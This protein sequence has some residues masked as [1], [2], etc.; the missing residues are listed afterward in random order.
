MQKIKRLLNYL[1]KQ[2]VP[3]QE[4]IK[5]WAEETARAVGNLP[6]ENGWGR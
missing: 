3:A 2:L 4:E 1:E 5:E 6:S